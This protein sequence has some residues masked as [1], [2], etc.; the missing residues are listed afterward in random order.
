MHVFTES[1]GIP[2]RPYLAW[3]RVQRS[4][5]AILAGASVTEAAH[6][7]GFADCPHMSRTFKRRLG[8]PPSALRRFAENRDLAVRMSVRRHLK[9]ASFS[10]CNLHR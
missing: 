7:A 4:A 1:I 6:M 3:L 8:F 10:K 2:L 5:C 9:C